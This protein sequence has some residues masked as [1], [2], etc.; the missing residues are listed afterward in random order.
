[1]SATG[2]RPRQFDD[3]GEVAVSVSAGVSRQQLEQL[4]QDII[5]S[6]NDALFTRLHNMEEVHSQ[7]RVYTSIIS[8]HLQVPPNNQP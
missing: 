1:M 8:K 3:V 5:T 6:L 2:T 7:L 4:R